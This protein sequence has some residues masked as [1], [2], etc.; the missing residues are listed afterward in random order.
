[1]QEDAAPL[2]TLLITSLVLIS[3]SEQNQFN[4]G[5]IVILVFI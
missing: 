5:V 3:V 4:G 2:A 1:M